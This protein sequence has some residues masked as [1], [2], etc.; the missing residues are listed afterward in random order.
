M[1]EDSM[2]SKTTIVPEKDTIDSIFSKLASHMTKGLMVHDQLSNY[3][4]FLGMDGF[5]EEHAEHS[6]DEANKLRELKRYYMS[7]YDKMLEP[8][9]VEEPNII[10]QSWYR[11]TRDE[12]D[13]NTK[14]NGVQNGL[15]EWHEWESNTKHEFE[16]AYKKLM[17]I[18]ETSAAFFV[19]DLIDGVIEELEDIS[20]R[21][22]RL[23]DEEFDLKYLANMQ[24]QI[25]NRKFQN[26]GSKRTYDQPE[27]EYR[28]SKRNTR[29]GYRPY[30]E[31]YE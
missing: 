21:T 6:N 28:R 15:K 9:K 8:A 7:N 25:Q 16:K 26:S 14:R 12:V 4:S 29:Y 27:S 18:D 3:Y 23:K 30:S 17:D 13:P 24:D 5:A 22:R 1:L 19:K 10:P 31:T 2:Q 20:K 11:H